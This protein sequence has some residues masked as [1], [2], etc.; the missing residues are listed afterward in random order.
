M[1]RFPSRPAVAFIC[2]VVVGTGQSLVWITAGQADHLPPRQ[3]ERDQRTRLHRQGDGSFT[4]CVHSLRPQ[5][6]NILVRSGLERWDETRPGH[7]SSRWASVDNYVDR[8]VLPPRQEWCVRLDPPI[9]R[10]MPSGRYRFW[11]SV[12]FEPVWNA[13]LN[14]YVT[15]TYG[16]DNVVFEI[17]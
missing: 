9:I 16:A 17:P 12:D 10:R 8:H 2:C 14:Q 4:V 11:V 3:S 7:L 1:R 13:Q 5:T 6:A 15:E